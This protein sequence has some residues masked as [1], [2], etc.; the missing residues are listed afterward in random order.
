MPFNFLL[1]H[2]LLPGKTQ[3]SE[4][5]CSA[6]ILPKSDE[7]VLAFRIDL[8]AFREEYDLRGKKL[9]DGFFFIFKA[10]DTRPKL[11][12]VELKGSDVTAAAE[13][14]IIAVTFLKQR[15][16]NFPSTSFQLSD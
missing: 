4:Q 7:T 15:S 16:G 3:I 10:G 2:C 11:I 14:L 1:W 6:R 9:C 8:E 13:Q 12:F 5:G